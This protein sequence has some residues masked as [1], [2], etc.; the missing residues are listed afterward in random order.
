MS[1]QAAPRPVETPPAAAPAITYRLATD[2]DGPAIGRLFAACDYGD[3]GVDW[4]AA[5][6]ARGWLLA[7]RDGTLV[8]AIQLFHGEPYSVVGDCV[9]LPEVRAKGATGAGT[10][11]KPGRVT[12]TLYVLA[13]DALKRAGSQMALGCTR[14]AG[15]VRIIGRYGGVP[16]GRAETFGKAL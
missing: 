3:L 4:H 9:V 7:D 13:L 5:N 8:G 6:V 1:A 10:F 15:M 2:A 11:G 12:L 14:K 16:L